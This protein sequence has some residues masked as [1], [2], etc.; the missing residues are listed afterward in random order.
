[1]VDDIFKDMRKEDMIGVCGFG[2]VGGDINYS[3]FEETKRLG[4]IESQ[5]SDLAHQGTS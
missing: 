1:M 5:K 3:S 2:L 4:E